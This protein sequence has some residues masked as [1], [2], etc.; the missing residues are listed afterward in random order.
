VFDPALEVIL[1]GVVDLGGN[2]KRQTYATGN[3]D[4]TIN[5]FL[6]CNSAKEG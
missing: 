6:R 2:A 1:V 5:T 4:G 3:V